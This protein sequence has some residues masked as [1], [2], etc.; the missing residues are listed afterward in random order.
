MLR[1]A[2]AFPMKRTNTTP[3]PRV[4]SRPDHL[5]QSISCCISGGAH[6]APK[7]RQPQD[8]NQKGTEGHRRPAH[9]V[10]TWH[11]LHPLSPSR[12]SPQR[13]GWPHRYP[14]S[15]SVQGC[16]LLAGVTGHRVGKT[17]SQG[18]DGTEHSAGFSKKKD[19]QGQKQFLSQSRG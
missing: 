6:A 4:R 11:K 9:H 14:V 7:V 18:S 13:G 5:T 2:T 10:P 3:G 17:S 1:D 19:L 8:D 16:L 12:Q 15:T